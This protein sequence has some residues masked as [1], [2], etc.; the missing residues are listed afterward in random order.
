[1]TLPP[2]WLRLV[3]RPSRTVATGG[4]DNRNSCGRRLCGQCRTSTACDNDRHLTTYKIGYHFWEPIVL[5]LGPTVSIVTFCP[6]TKPLSLSPSRNAVTFRAYPFGDP[7]LSHPITGIDDCCARAANGH[8]C[9]GATDKCDKFPSPHSVAHC[10]GLRY[11]RNNTFWI[12]NYAVRY[13]APLPCPLCAISGHR[14][15]FC[16][17]PTHGPCS[18]LIIWLRPGL[19]PTTSGR[20]S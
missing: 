11:E 17:R 15:R 5:T 4:E 13:T 14:D 2:G 16:K 19:A 7:P 3:T 8:A 10:Q 1:V 12:E 6:S 20:A 18:P 9:G